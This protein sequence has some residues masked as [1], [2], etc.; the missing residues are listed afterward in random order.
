[1]TPVT[2]PWRYRFRSLSRGGKGW[3]RWR[4]PLTHSPRLPKL[5]STEQQAYKD[6]A[7]AILHEKGI[8]RPELRLTQVIRVD[9][10][11]DGSEE[12]LV[13]ATQYAKG[14]SA[15]ASP[16]D[17]SM[18]FMRRVL[19]DKVVTSLLEGDFF[20][21][22]VDFGAPG[23]HR[24][25]TVLDLNGDGVMEIVLFGRYY[26]GDWA[27]VFRVEGDKIVKILTAGCGV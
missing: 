14:L 5:Q 11:G 25:G 12:V 22:G 10:D 21:R 20:P 2:I 4:D 24:V 19:K 18:V 27:A 15:S 7:A 3:W 26:E 6:A 17:Y 16:G 8:A 1:M 9:L 23:E 13:S